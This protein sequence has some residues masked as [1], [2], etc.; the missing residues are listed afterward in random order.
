MAED[1]GGPSTAEAGGDIPIITTT[2]DPTAADATIA[3]IEDARH[4]QPLPG[5]WAENDF[6]SYHGDDDKGNPQTP[7][8][9]K[10]ANG[11]TNQALREDMARLSD[12]VSQLTTM[13]T[14]MWQG[15]KP[16]YD[17][18][19]GSVFAKRPG[20][21]QNAWDPRGQHGE[22]EDS[23]PKI[24]VPST[25]KV[26]RLEIKFGSESPEQAQAPNDHFNPRLAAIA[27]PEVPI[28]GSTDGSSPFSSSFEESEEPSFESS[29]KIDSPSPRNRQAEQHGS[30]SS[31]KNGLSSST[32]RRPEERGPETSVKDGSPASSSSFSERS[33]KQSTEHDSPIA[34][35]TQ[36]NVT[37][38]LQQTHDVEK[39]AANDAMLNYF[40][41]YL[42]NPNR[43]RKPITERGDVTP[44]MAK[45]FRDSAQDRR[46]KKMGMQVKSGVRERILKLSKDNMVDLYVALSQRYYREYSD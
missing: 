31:D 25:A 32:D 17:A 11:P 15:Y 8:P 24:I 45:S 12:Q 16:P 3:A 30:E 6:G 22:V 35:G 33:P 9:T 20:T 27:A 4:R 7:M 14:Q 36:E 13:V 21:M 29:G 1:R 26:A 40:I 39:L 38:G 18:N 19:G 2:T 34:K 23:P 41:H 42:S 28:P 43:D 5:V 37:E 10:M 44:A 46:G